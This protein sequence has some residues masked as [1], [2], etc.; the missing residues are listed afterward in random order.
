MY[1]KVW[2]GAASGLDGTEWDL[3]LEFDESTGLFQVS[4][5]VDGEPL[6]AMS[7]PTR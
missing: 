4:V 3:T 1:E 5:S 6:T 2:E 7:A